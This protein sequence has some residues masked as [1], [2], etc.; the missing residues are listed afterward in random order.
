MTQLRKY[1]LFA[2]ACLI[3]GIG[4]AHA[5]ITGTDSTHQQQQFRVGQMQIGW[6]VATGNAVTI[7][8]GSGVITTASLTTAQG[9]VTPITLTNSR[10]QVGDMVQCTVDPMSSAGGPF[11]AN[12]AV[13]NGQIVFN[14]GNFAA[15]A[16]NNTVRIYWQIN[17]AGNAN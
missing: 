1:V 4:A 9:A 13:T 7:T 2:A 6:G 10:V 11:C 14:V 15:A 17:K 8:A 12:A 3:L 5:I 16:L